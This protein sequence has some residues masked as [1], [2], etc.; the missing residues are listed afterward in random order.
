MLTAIILN[1]FVRPQL[2]RP[3][4]SAGF[5][6]QKYDKAISSSMRATNAICTE[7]L[8]YQ[9]YRFSLLSIVMFH[10]VCKQQI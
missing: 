10:F 1:I 6:Y 7:F 5:P 8:F 4:R 9:A 3:S 2:P